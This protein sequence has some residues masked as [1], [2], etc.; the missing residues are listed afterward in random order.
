MTLEGLNIGIEVNHQ[1][2]PCAFRTLA[3]HFYEKR[4][5]LEFVGR[6]RQDD[7]TL[8]LSRYHSYFSE[9]AE[10][11]FKVPAAASRQVDL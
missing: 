7:S 8:G 6:R 2:I 9:V 1:I 10:S 3:G 4:L 5:Y 11:E